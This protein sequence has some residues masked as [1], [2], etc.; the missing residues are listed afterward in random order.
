MNESLFI[1]YV[2]KFFPK[3]TKLIEL[4]NGKRKELTYL[5]KTMLR[6]EYSADQKWQSAS[7]KT[8]FVAADM[9]AMDSPLPIKKRDSV[10]KASG[11]LPKI[12]MKKILR[13]TDINT[14]NIM[15][16]QGAEFTQIAQKLS[17][18]AVAC[19]TGIDEKNEANFLSALSNGYVLVEDSEN[20]GTGLRVDFGYLASNCFGVETAG[21]ISS[22]DIKRVIAK[23]D[24]DGNSIQVIAI[25]LSTYNKL[26]QTRWAKELVANYKGQAFTDSTNLPVPTA[27]IFDEAFSDDNNGI[28][29]LKV[30]RSVIAEKNGNRNAYKPWNANKLI[31][32]TTEEVGA[33]VW[34]TLAEK[35]NPV[36]G[37]VYT[38]V[39]DY[40]LIS[41]YSKTDPLQEFTTGQALVLPVIENV[42]QIYS[43]D[44]S[45]A[46][47]IAATEDE[48]DD[49]ITIYGKS[50]VKSSVI[51]ALNAIGVTTNVNISDANLIK[52][53]NQLNDEDE[54]KLKAKLSI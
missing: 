26:R 43:L 44:L 6:K 32:L 13:E 21:E 51:S 46:Q 24:E 38:T 8:N 7:L 54:A 52:K 22:D 3:L 42:D 41:K 30:D 14:I 53:V 49:N 12:G 34:G 35:T 23:A 4:I 48:S 31:F 19:S 11:V 20:V 17:A 33:L 27:T 2:Q 36:E 40:K 37:V 1:E 15:K 9:V 18:D 10:G 5:H 45:E 50:L 25:A 47:E 28:S 16:A 39:D 29:F